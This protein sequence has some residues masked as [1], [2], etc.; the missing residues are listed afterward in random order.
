MI[1]P[2][3]TNPRVYDSNRYEYP[4]SEVSA[5]GKYDVLTRLNIIMGRSCDTVTA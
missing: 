1:V 5:I 3:K 2:D 4:A